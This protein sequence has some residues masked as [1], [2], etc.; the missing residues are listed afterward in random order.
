MAL[1][2]CQRHFPFPPLRATS[3]RPKFNPGQVQRICVPKPPAL[4]HTTR[5]SMQTTKALTTPRTWVDRLPPKA[6]PYLYLTRIDKPIG[7]LL[8]F[9]PCGASS[10]APGPVAPPMVGTDHRDREI[11]RSL[12]NH[13]GLIR[14]QRP[15][16]CPTEIHTPVRHRRAHHARGRVHHQRPMGPEPGQRSRYVCWHVIS[17]SI[18]SSTAPRTQA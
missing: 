2:R 11:P 7:T 14:A 16:I 17:S 10:A 4:F 13:D 12:V 3:L 5:S 9:Y 1:W 18:S 8:L 15:A 6:Q